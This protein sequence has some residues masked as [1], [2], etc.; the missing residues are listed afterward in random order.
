MLSDEKG[1]A[2]IPSFPNSATSWLVSKGA[3]L[4]W[5]AV[6]SQW[7]IEETSDGGSEETG[8]DDDDEAEDKEAEDEEDEEEARDEDAAGR[9][10]SSRDC[11]ERVEGCTPA[12]SSSIISLAA[13][14]TAA[15][16]STMSRED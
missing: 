5:V 8:G 11:S 10:G 9:E 4:S 14:G 7:S 16:L 3:K 2:S 6:D 1:F 13:P 12:I 15:S